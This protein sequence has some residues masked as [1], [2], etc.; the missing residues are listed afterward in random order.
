SAPVLG[1]RCP[2]PRCY[3]DLPHLHSFPTRRSSDLPGAITYI[4]RMDVLVISGYYPDGYFESNPIDISQVGKAAATSITWEPQ[5]GVK[6]LTR[7]SL[8]AGNTWSEWAETEPGNIPGITQS[9]DLTN[10]QFQYRVV[11]ET[12]DVATSPAFNNLNYTL[13][14]AYKPTG[15]WLSPPISLEDANI[16]GDSTIFFTWDG[17]QDIQLEARVNGGVWQPVENG[18]E[19]PGV[20]GTEGAVVEVR[21]TLSTA[22]TSE[23]PNID[24][25][26]VTAKE[27]ID[28][29]IE[30]G[31]TAPG[32]PVFYIDVVDELDSLQI[33]HVESGRFVLLEGNFQPG[34]A[35]VI[36]HNDQSITLN[37][38]YRLD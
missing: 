25:L 4:S 10:A 15:Q 22:D 9:T 28:S 6:I 21:L 19:I 1:L 37:G 23:T 2:S 30:Y 3:A 34:D 5:Q 24:S 20:R 26:E 16:V 13:T 7:V 8:D 32:Y 12:D 18:G 11:L 35:I 36:D 33:L 29:S 17:I 31:G 14:A 27:A 38:V